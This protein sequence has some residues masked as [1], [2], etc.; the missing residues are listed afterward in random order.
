MRPPTT[1][2]SA[3]FMMFLVLW[4]VQLIARGV[5]GYEIPLQKQSYMT[6]QG[7]A[8]HRVPLHHQG[9]Q[10][11][12]TFAVSHGV[13]GMD[14]NCNSHNNDEPTTIQ[15]VTPYNFLA[16]QVWP[17][18]RFAA[19][20]IEQ[21]LSQHLLVDMAGTNPIIL[22]EF[23]CGPGLPSLTAATLYHNCHVIATDIDVLAL[24]LVRQAAMAQNVSDRVTTQLFDLTNTCTNRIPVADIY[25][26]SDVFESS[27]VAKGAANITLRILK[28]FTNST[29]W[30]LAQSDRAQR[31]IYI[32]ELQQQLQDPTLTW[33][34]HDSQPPVPHHMLTSHNHDRNNSMMI[35]NT[36]QT[37]K[38]RLWLCNIDETQVFYG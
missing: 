8:V 14:S 4:T 26:F 9:V 37:W 18:A 19:R 6:V 17:S 33:S 31:E 25:I 15:V 20:V 2:P 38:D 22:C 29:I 35:H 21:Y 3:P 1:T 12:Y 11:P 28:E 10:S 24:E 32:K 16:T 23:G 13:G 30:V 36:D 5:V 34:Q 7:R 27:L